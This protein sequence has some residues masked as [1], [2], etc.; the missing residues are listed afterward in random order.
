MR[1]EASRPRGDLKRHQIWQSLDGE[2]TMSIRISF[3]FADDF[4]RVSH[5]PHRGG[6]ISRLRAGAARW[7]ERR[8]LEELD[9]RALR[10]M[11]I[12]RSQAL[13]EAAK[14]FWRP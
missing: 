1:D 11:G 10:D 3:A 5:L 8:A 9:G 2:F 4:S 14:P 12:S 6:L 7:R 13:V